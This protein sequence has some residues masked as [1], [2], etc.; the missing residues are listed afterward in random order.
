MS[1]ELFLLKNNLTLPHLP[2]W[3]DSELSTTSPRPCPLIDCLHSPMVP[4]RAIVLTFMRATLTSIGDKAC[5][6]HHSTQIKRP[7]LQTI[8]CF[9]KRMPTAP[10]Q[11][12]CC[13][14]TFHSLRAVAAE[15]THADTVVKAEPQLTTP[16]RTRES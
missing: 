3:T 9:P 7:A 5:P 16:A 14:R 13:Q 6:S 15:A 4:A 2:N 11:A 12:L 10:T 8:L 1:V